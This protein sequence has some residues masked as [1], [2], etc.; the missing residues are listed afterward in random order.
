MPRKLPRDYKAEYAEYHGKPTQVKNRATRNAARK[1][2]EKA[3]RVR[4]GDGKEV[5]HKRGVEKGNGDKNLKVMSR[6]AN[7]KKQ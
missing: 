5:D 3:G 4:K 1:K 6:T 2:M 7:R